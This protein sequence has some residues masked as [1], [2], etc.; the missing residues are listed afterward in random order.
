M[1][2]LRLALLRV[3]VVQMGGAVPTPTPSGR[4]FATVPNPKPH[5]IAKGSSIL[6]SRDSVDCADEAGMYK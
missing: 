6:L 1:S 5:L 2:I 3:V 4:I